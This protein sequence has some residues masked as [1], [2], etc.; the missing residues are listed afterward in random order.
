MA[1]NKHVAIEG[2]GTANEKGKYRGIKMGS[3]SFATLVKCFLATR[4]KGGE[5]RLCNIRERGHH[6]Q[7]H[8][9]QESRKD[10]TS[11]TAV[12]NKKVGK[13]WK[14]FAAT[15]QKK[16]LESKRRNWNDGL[17]P[18]TEKTLT[19]GVLG[20]RKAGLSFPQISHSD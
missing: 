16:K 5:N 8:E 11:A 19:K 4:R 10:N 1:R 9:K 2:G 7:L 3:H 20:G 18:W 17:L 6:V 15:F 14:E 12:R 13:T